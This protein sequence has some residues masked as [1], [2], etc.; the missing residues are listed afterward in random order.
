MSQRTVKT[1][2]YLKKASMGATIVF[3]GLIISSFLGYLV[4]MMIVRF[5]GIDDYGLFS[6]GTAIVG[7]AIIV[8]MLG[9]QESITRFVSFHLGRKAPE[10]AKSTVL[11][12][13]KVTIPMSIAAAAIVILLSYQ[14]SFN[15]FNEPTLYP[16]LWAFAVMIPLSVI[17]TNIISTLKGLHDMKHKVYSED[18]L[19]SFTTLVLVFLFFFLGSGIMGILYAYMIGFVLSILLAS[20]YL[21]RSFPAMFRGIRGIPFQ[22]ELM[23]FSWPLLLAAYAKM[24]VSWTDTIALGFFK[25][26]YDVGLYNVALPTAGLILIFLNSFRYI[27]V[28]VVSELF[29]KKDKENMRTVFNSVNKWLYYITFPAFLLMILFPD[30]IMIILFGSEAVGASVPFVILSFGF[31]MFSVFSLSS[32]LLLIIGKTKTNMFI[33]ILGSTT[34]LVL[35][36][37]L[38]PTFGINGAAVSTSISFVIISLLSALYCYMHSGFFPVQKVFTKPMVAGTISVL[39]FYALLKF[40]I[41]NF[42]WPILI[43]SFPPFIVLYTFLLF[44]MGGLDKNDLMILRSIE[45]RTG[46]RSNLLR[47]IIRRFI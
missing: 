15:F 44:V 12:S 3:I 38:I 36:I 26:S 29:G 8:S 40:I 30:N 9:M 2:S 6:L 14:I 13:M 33:T 22:R 32:T 47:R 28:P 34:N 43:L 7:I 17:L 11:S 45:S 39:A 42:T 18:I 25:T 31:F 46:L 21:Y 24:I 16:I 41:M 5:Y 35:N 27:F 4:R 23:Y 10:R 19:K 20:F 1:D 37:L